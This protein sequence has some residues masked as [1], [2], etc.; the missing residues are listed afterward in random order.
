MCWLAS[1]Q[2]A[3]LFRLT[4]ADKQGAAD[5]VEEF[6]QDSEFDVGM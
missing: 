3:A 4:F 5:L 2:D 1:E 6:L